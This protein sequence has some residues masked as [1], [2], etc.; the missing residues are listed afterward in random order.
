MFCA[1]ACRPTWRRAYCK[2][3]T[4][5]A[6]SARERQ[7]AGSGPTSN[8]LSKWPANWRLAGVIVGPSGGAVSSARHFS[9]YT[10]HSSEEVHVDDDDDDRPRAK[11]LHC[12]RVDN[13]VNI[14]NVCV[15]ICDRRTCVRKCVVRQSIVKC[16]SRYAHVRL[17]YR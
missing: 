4:H 5:T 7:P 16:I 2:I 8:S 12:T 17:F 6:E 15:R 14:V 10:I 13:V 1:F 3:R 9:L 11:C